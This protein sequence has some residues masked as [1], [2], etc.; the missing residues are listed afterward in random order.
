[1]VRSAISVMAL[2]VA[3]PALAETPRVLVVGVPD[4]AAP[5]AFADS[6]N[7]A[8]ALRAAGLTE[9]TLLR[10]AS[11]AELRRVWDEVDPDLLYMSGPYPVELSRR[12][13][14]ETRPDIL[15]LDDCARP[16]AVSGDGVATASGANLC[17]NGGI[18]A[19][20]SRA[21]APQISRD[22]N[23]VLSSAWSG[24]PGEAFTIEAPTAASATGPITIAQESVVAVTPISPIAP[25]SAGAVETTTLTGTAVTGAAVADAAAGAGGSE[26]VALFVSTP[27]SQLPALPT[28]DGFPE[29]SI[30]LG[31]IAPTL[32]SF[33]TAQEDL[34]VEAANA[35]A[36]AGAEI[37]YQNVEA[38][39][40]LKESDPVLF[41][42]LVA[43]GAFDPPDTEIVIAL[44]TELTRM[45]CYSGGIDNQWGGGSRRGVDR[46]FNQLN[47]SGSSDPT[48]ELFR[49]ILRKDDVKCP[50]PAPVAAR[51][52]TTRSTTTRR[53]TTRQTTTRQ[54]TTRQAPARQAPARSTT[55]RTLS[56]SGGAL[57]G[58]FR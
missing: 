14:V 33:P 9:V 39:R 56:G 43:G 38:R 28:P 34:G 22:F 47:E 23:G 54:T 4:A 26:N 21:S 57:I 20:I 48:V 3:L 13:G 1:M 5:M 36:L 25:V 51:Q 41:E 18:A 45:E 40:A 6:Y 44:Q 12:L 37:S 2:T 11:V 24:A 31:V 35:A 15:L 46:Y 58:T 50:P 8:Q 52:T 55:R 53:T 19:L 42:T 17:D 30:I 27:A 10:D 32:A 49:Q 7:V 16:V 29:P